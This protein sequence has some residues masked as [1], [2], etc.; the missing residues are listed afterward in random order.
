MIEVL[1]GESEAGSMRCAKSNKKICKANDGPT[2]V[3]G[4]PSLLPERKDWI[5]IPGNAGEVVCLSFLLDV[6][7]IQESFDS[8]YRMD[9]ILSMY[10]QS[11][12]EKSEEFINELKDGIRRNVKEYDRLQNFLKEGQPIRIWYSHAAYSL[13]GFYWLCNLLRD[14]ENKIYVVELPEYLENAENNTIRKYHNWGE[15]SEEQFSSFLDLQRQVSKNERRMFGQKWTELVEDNS[16]LR[17]VINH[18]LMGVPENFYDF[19]ILK[20]ITKEPVKEARLIGNILGKYPLCVGDW[21][22]A[23]RIEQMIKE[24]RMKVLQDSEQ[25]YTRMVCLA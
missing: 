1:F 5:P 6:G 9:L 15:M 18:E 8:Q 21:W 2:Y 25:K 13:C 20:S 3:W 10:T 11:G 7:N 4:D 19:L 22:Y 17:A 24:G 16:P 14:A 12:W 23:Y